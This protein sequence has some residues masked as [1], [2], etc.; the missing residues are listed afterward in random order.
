M[1]SY[2]RTQ[3]ARMIQDYN[4]QMMTQYA[5]RL[6]PS[7]DIVQDETSL[8]SSN[9]IA[10][11]LDEQTTPQPTAQNELTDI[12]NLQIRVSTENQAVPL[13]GAVVTISHTA[14]GN[15]IIDRTII[16]DQSGLTPIIALPTK[17]R[18]LSLTPGAIDPFAVYTVN[19][20]ADGYF[21][22]QFTD[23]PIYGGVTAIQSVSMIPLPEAG[24]DDIVLTYPQ[25]GPSL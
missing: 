7:V 12:G 22:K 17:D 8:T 1:P 21:P 24:G 18:A 10:E 3:L 9:I 5:D 19:V 25:S 20:T 4:Q 13:G 16:T 14:D 15:Q 2:D 6:Q 23:L 11:T